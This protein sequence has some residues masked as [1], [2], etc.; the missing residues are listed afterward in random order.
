MTT[1]MAVNL[2][3]AELDVTILQ[4]P[5]E[6]TTAPAAD[7]E[8]TFNNQLTEVQEYETEPDASFTP[9]TKKKKATPATAISSKLN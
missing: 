3:E 5:E 6:P 8:V 7:Q 1:P 4:M 2:T 9:V